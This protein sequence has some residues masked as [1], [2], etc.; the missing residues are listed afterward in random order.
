MPIK[1]IWGDIQDIIESS[2]AWD[3]EFYDKELKNPGYPLEM[4][5]LNFLI[6]HFILRSHK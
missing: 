3:I 2:L 6:K 5:S 1:Q 4:E